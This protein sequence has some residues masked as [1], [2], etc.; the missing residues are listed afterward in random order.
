[1][2]QRIN[3]SSSMVESRYVYIH[4]YCYLLVNCTCS[5]EHINTGWLIALNMNVCAFLCG[6]SNALYCQLSVYDEDGTR[7]P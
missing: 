3:Q 2:Q 1:M 6:G 4:H 5:F 7:R